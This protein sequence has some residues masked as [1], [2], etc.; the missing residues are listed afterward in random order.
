M[1]FSSPLLERAVR[2]ELDM[3]QG[4]VTAEDLERVRRLAVI[5]QTVPGREQVYEYRLTGYLDGVS[6]RGLE[7]GD[8]SDL[9]LLADMPNLRELYLCAQQITDLSCLAG[10]PLESLYLCDN[11]IRDLT[12][13]AECAALQTLYLGC[14][15]LD[16]LG[17]LASLTGL[18]RLNL[19]QWDA[20]YPVDSLQPIADLPLEYLSLGNL[21]PADGGWD[22]LDR[23]DGV[24]E[25]W[26]S[27]PPEQAAAHLP[28]MAGLQALSVY[29]F[30]AAGELDAL[31]LPALTSLPLYGGAGRLDWLRGLEGL[32]ALSLCGPGRFDLEPLA[33]LEQLQYLYLFD[34]EI[35]DYSPLSRAPAL[36]AVQADAQAA[37]AVEAACPGHTFALNP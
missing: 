31:P 4:A 26:L 7:G 3:P 6:Q 1:E 17:P 20:P 9:S 10:L 5:G 28:E 24:R 37:A 27:D 25:L 16:D 8:I 19:D 2:A 33:E 22:A 36:R 13:L 32:G 14:N 35:E 11:Q 23:L 30:R 15:P 29:N 18:R 21:I 34:C 12:P